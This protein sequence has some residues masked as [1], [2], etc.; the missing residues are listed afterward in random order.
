MMKRKEAIW[1]KENKKREDVRFFKKLGSR[2]SVL[3]R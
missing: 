3:S 1:K 2:D